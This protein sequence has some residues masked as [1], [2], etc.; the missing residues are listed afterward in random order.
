MLVTAGGQRRQICVGRR[1]SG[2]H[3]LRREGQSDGDCL[4]ATAATTPSPLQH[5]QAAGRTVFSRHL[6]M[7]LC[8]LEHLKCRRLACPSGHG[9]ELLS[10]H[11]MFWI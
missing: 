5:V 6:D 1:P 11:G 7:E 10:F 4:P 2:H 8:L 9:R 3:Q